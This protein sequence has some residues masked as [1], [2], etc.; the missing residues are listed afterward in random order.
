M[1]QE[2]FNIVD[3]SVSKASN[4][5]PIGVIGLGLLGSA[6]ADRLIENGYVVYGFDTGAPRSNEVIVLGSSRAVLERCATVILSL[7]ESSDV[8][9]MLDEV[10]DAL[11]P[12]R[13][14]FVDT[15]TGDPDEMRQFYERLAKR[16]IGYIEANIAGSSEAAREGNSPLFLGGAIKAIE[17][18]KPLFEAL[19]KSSFNMGA[20]GSASRFKLVHNLMLGLNRAVLAETLVFGEALGFDSRE[21]LEVLKKT[22][23]SS[24]VMVTKGERM[25]QSDFDQPQARLSQHLKDVRLILDQAGRSGA[26]TPLSETHCQLLESLE[27]LGYGECDNSAILAAYQAGTETPRTKEEVRD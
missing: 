25:V 22:P 27:K 12:G 24:Y 2:G 11:E 6:L 23:A 7:P 21:T 19:S 8:G 3:G 20:A 13:H 17:E 1:I 18:K 16:E 5:E 14:T 4:N 26:R 15:T 10:S 9:A